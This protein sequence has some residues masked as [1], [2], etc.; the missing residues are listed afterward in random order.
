[1]PRI[2]PIEDHE[3]NE[4]RRF[5]ILRPLKA[6]QSLGQRCKLFRFAIENQNRKLPC[7]H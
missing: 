2:R 5:L 1:M 4:S 7:M 6:L 3:A